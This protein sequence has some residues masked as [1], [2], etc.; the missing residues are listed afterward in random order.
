MIDD[1]EQRFLFSPRQHPR[2]KDLPTQTPRLNAKDSKP[3]K[4]SLFK[5][6]KKKGSCIDVY[7]CVSTQ[8]VLLQKKS[9]SKS[10]PFGPKRAARSIPPRRRARRRVPLPRQGASPALGRAP[11]RRRS[12]MSSGV[13]KLEP[14]MRG[15]RAMSARARQAEKA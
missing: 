13:G 1:P 4:E 2:S 6:I 15:K 8:K 14:P 11:T 5:Y 10:L 3:K 12:G 9:Q 7:R